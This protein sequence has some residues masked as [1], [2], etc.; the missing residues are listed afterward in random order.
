MS[1]EVSGGVTGG[2]VTGEVPGGEALA[3]G[4]RTR[5]LGEADPAARDVVTDLLG[6]AARGLP[7]MRTGVNGALGRGF[8]FTMRGE[9]AVPAGTSVR[10]AAIVALGARRLPVDAQRAVL[11]GESARELVS[12]LVTR[13]ERTG[14]RGVTSLGDIALICWAAAEV[15]DGGLDLALARLAAA[16]PEGGGPVFTV[17]AAWV[18]AALAAVRDA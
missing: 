3:G 16:D 2:E 7:R 18:A 5:R 9:H 15:G 14:A 4:A 12:G 17:D 11:G 10:Y 8:V 13:L 1:G 6:R